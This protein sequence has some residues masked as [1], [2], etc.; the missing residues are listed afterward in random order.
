[1]E[2]SCNLQPSTATGL[3]QPGHGIFFGP[4]CDLRRKWCQLWPRDMMNN[5]FLACPNGFP[6]QRFSGLSKSS[7]QQED[8]VGLIPHHIW[9]SEKHVSKVIR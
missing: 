8:C 7:I 2:P 1:M 3:V 9:T 4:D 5:E 6:L